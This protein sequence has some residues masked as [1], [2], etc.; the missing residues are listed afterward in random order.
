MPSQKNENKDI[1][2]VWQ[3]TLG[4]WTRAP[5]VSGFGAQDQEANIGI[6][7]EDEDINV[8]NYN[9]QKP[10]EKC[11]K[12]IDEVAKNQVEAETIAKNQVENYNMQEP[13]EKCTKGIDE[14]AK[15]QVEA[16]TMAKNQVE[17]KGALRATKGSMVDVATKK[18]SRARSASATCRTIPEHEEVGT[19]HKTDNQSSEG[20]GPRP[21]L[22]AEEAATD[23]LLDKLFG[24]FGYSVEDML[25]NEQGSNLVGAFRSLVSAGHGEAVAD[26][27]QKML[28]MPS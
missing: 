11:N 6:T 17:A 28:A 3:E 13:S 1:E 12:S 18:A 9:M 5:K 24:K 26:Q 15:N 10:S 19:K 25:N 22:W 8:E 21:E 2:K 4:F 14:G 27:V 23:E 7:G 20:K 16:K